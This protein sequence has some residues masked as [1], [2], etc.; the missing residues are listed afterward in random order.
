MESPRPSLPGAVVGGHRSELIRIKLL[1]KKT[2][3]VRGVRSK[4]SLWVAIGIWLFALVLYVNYYIPWQIWLLE[5]SE[6]IFG[7]DAHISFHVWF[8]KSF[9]ISFTDFLYIVL[10]VIGAGFFL[11]AFLLPALEKAR[12]FRGTDLYCE[13]CDEVIPPYDDWTCPDCKHVNKVDA[14]ATKKKIKALRKARQYFSF[15]NPEGCAKCGRFPRALTCPHCQN[16]ISLDDQALAQA[17]VKGPGIRLS[18]QSYVPVEPPPLT[19][20]EVYEERLSKRLEKSKLEL[21]YDLDRKEAGVNAQME[22]LK[23]AQALQ[24]NEQSKLDKELK[25]GK[26]GEEEY[27]DR[28]N[29]LVNFIAMNSTID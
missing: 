14:V 27:Q 16:L 26:I 3:L 20:T 18:L 6:S 4:I 9:N 8:A 11:L 19:E 5:L 29:Q 15:L 17:D 13:H 25:A 1:K 2:A 24:E 22:W 23:R 21:A 12:I 7:F 10:V 28:C